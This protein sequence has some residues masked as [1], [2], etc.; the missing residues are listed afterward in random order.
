MNPQRAE[1]D[2]VACNGRQ[3]SMKP[4]TRENTLAGFDCTAANQFDHARDDPRMRKI[5]PLNPLMRFGQDLV[6]VQ[7]DNGK[8]WFDLIEHVRFKKV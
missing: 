3:C 7:V 5:D 6:P 8:L 2:I 4:G 1:G